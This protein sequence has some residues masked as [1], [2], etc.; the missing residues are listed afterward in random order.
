MT[1][2]SADMNFQQE[3]NCS[4]VRSSLQEVEVADCS[5]CSGERSR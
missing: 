1:Y 3:Q 5:V 4:T 2:N